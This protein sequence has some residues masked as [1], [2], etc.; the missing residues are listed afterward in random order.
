MLSLEIPTRVC[1]QQPHGLR[2]CHG[3]PCPFLRR[4]SRELRAA[5]HAPVPI[6][7]LRRARTCGDICSTLPA[8]R[9]SLSASIPSGASISVTDG[10][11]IVRVPVLSNKST[12]ARAN[13]SKCATT[14]DD[15][16]ASRSPRDPG[17]DRY[18][19]CQ[20]QWARSRD[21]QDG[22]SSNG[23]ARDE[24]GTPAMTSVVGMNTSAYRSASLTNGALVF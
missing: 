18:R 21:D 1:Q 10:R 9:R 23:I 22:H 7:Q 3:C 19:R 5:G 8:K 16:A 17:D 24:P 6:E 13:V 14:F 20:D 4:R 2:P 11:P 15:H 12:R